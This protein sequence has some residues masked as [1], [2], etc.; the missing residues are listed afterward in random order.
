VAERHL[1]LNPA[2]G[3]L[4]GKVQGKAYRIDR[5]TMDMTLIVRPVS[6]LTRGPDGHL[7]LSRDQNFWTYRFC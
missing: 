6:N 5:A 4:Y 3:H 7:Y 2:D 1:T